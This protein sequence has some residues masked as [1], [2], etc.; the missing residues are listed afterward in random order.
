MKKFI[1]SKVIFLYMG[2]GGVA[3]IALILGLLFMAAIYFIMV[4]LN[5]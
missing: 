3:G 4:Y 1:F 2:R 5:K